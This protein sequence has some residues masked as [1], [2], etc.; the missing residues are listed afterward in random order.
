LSSSTTPGDPPLLGLSSISPSPLSFSSPESPYHGSITFRVR[1]P[2]HSVSNASD[3]TLDRLFCRLSLPPPN[4]LHYR[5]FQIL[6]S[7]PVGTSSDPSL[8][9]LSNPDAAGT[10]VTWMNH[11]GITHRTLYTEHPSHTSLSVTVS[12]TRDAHLVFPSVVPSSVFV[13]TDMNDSYPSSRRH[14]SLCFL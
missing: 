13:V 2:L 3:I 5:L 6:R 1:L 9:S 14:S 12:F 11:R 4:T 7:C 10:R 8:S